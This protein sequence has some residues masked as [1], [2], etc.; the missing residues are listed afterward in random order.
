M[1]GVNGWLAELKIP[2]AEKEEGGQDEEIIMGTGKGL[3]RGELR[4]FRQ[5]SQDKKEDEK[6]SQT[7]PDVRW[8]SPQAGKD[9]SRDE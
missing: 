9:N 1:E 3:K 6:E 5:A 8:Q 7:E 4:D 2:R